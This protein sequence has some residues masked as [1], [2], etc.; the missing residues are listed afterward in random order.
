MLKR[1]FVA[2]MN[3]EIGYE[4]SRREENRAWKWF[5]THQHSFSWIAEYYVSFYA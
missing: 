5:K 1:D 3:E 4:M 2:A